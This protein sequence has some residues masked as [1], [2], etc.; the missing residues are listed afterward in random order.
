MDRVRQDEVRAAATRHV[1]MT[2]N[3]TGQ[4]PGTFEVRLGYA[5]GRQCLAVVADGQYPAASDEYMAQAEVFGGEDASIGKQ[6]QQRRGPGKK[7]AIY[8]TTASPPDRS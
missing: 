5:L 4:Q 7:G 3:E 6:F 2:V 1:R 8:Y